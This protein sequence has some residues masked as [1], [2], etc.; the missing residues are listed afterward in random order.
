MWLA[1]RSS[2]TAQETSE[3]RDGHVC[4]SS[5]HLDTVRDIWHVLLAYYSAAQR[6]ILTGRHLN[7][8]RGYAGA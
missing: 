4:P 2:L 3:Y 7:S 8:I 1:V 6:H 5:R